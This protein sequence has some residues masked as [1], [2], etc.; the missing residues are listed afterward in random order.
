VIGRNSRT[1]RGWKVIDKG[2]GTDHTICC[3]SNSIVSSFIWTTKNIEH[4][5]E[6]GIEPAEAEHVV[7]NAKSPY[8]QVL[9]R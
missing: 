2:Y 9:G 6:H 4:I 5:A 1:S 3:I 8:P 7:T